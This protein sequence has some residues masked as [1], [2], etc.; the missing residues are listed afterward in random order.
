MKIFNLPQILHEYN[1]DLGNGRVLFAGKTV[2]FLN[3]IGEGI[4]IA[5][6]CEYTATEA[7]K[8]TYTRDIDLNVLSLLVTYNNN[9]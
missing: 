5:L 2:K 8:S 6:S 1:V 3:P 4:S 7:I 9:I